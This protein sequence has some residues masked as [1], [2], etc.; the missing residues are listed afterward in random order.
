MRKIDAENPVI[1]VTSIDYTCGK[2]AVP[3]NDNGVARVAN[4]AAGSNITYQFVPITPCSHHSIIH[5][6]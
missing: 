1:D 2:Y 3:I 6:T 4:V 5:T